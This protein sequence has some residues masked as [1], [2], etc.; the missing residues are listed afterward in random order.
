MTELPEPTWRMLL[1]RGLPTFAL[2]GFVPVLAFYTAWHAAGLAA[3]IVASAATAALV[4]LIQLRR[5]CDVAL[6]AATGVFIAIQAVIA[7][8]AHSATV[9]LAQP[10][11]LTAC[12]GVAYLVS[13][14][15]DRPL[16]GAFARGWYPFPP[17]FRASR[18]YR[19]EFGMQSIV[20]G[21]YCLTAAALRIIVLLT[22]GV[23]SLVVVSFVTSTPVLL[24][25]VLWCV[26]HARRT[27]TTE[28]HYQQPRSI[29]VAEAGSMQL[30]R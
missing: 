2:E 27:F 12:W 7:L 5:G 26:W 1:A 4:V 16:M 24:V 13:A 9:Y 6:A 20:W 10:V 28:P 14:A 23:G 25:L 29:P 22:V 8:A 21:V 15:I 11:L 3:G 30:R 18:A 17:E 19:R